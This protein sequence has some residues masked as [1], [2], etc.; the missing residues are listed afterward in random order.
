M[1]ECELTVRLFF[2]EFH[3]SFP[4]LKS[5]PLWNNLV[6][7][8]V[9]TTRCY[10]F[11]CKLMVCLHS[12]NWLL[13]SSF[14]EDFR[15]HCQYLNNCCYLVLNFV[16][17]GEDYFQSLSCTFILHFLSQLSSHP[18]PHPQWQLKNLFFLLVQSNWWFDYLLILTFSKTQR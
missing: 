1:R 16:H 7:T 14:F 9:R 3:R 4:I 11:Y 6:F 5:S 8:W 12:V 17:Q 18:P 10:L 13:S 15:E 2:G